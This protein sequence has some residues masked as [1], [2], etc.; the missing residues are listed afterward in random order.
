MD[1]EEGL[2]KGLIIWTPEEVL[3][4]FIEAIKR[5]SIPGFKAADGYK[6][7]YTP[8]NGTG[9]ECVTRIL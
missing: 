9:V 2:E 7:V 5:V 1:F 8:L 6:V 4:N 3:D